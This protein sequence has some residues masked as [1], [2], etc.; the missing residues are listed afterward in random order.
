MAGELRCDRSSGNW[1]S[2]LGSALR[3][4]GSA[5]GKEEKREQER[6]TGRS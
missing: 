6:V 1:T 4:N 3:G 2:F 5:E